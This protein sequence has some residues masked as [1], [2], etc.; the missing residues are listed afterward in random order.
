MN[1]Q[2]RECVLRRLSFVLAWTGLIVFT[3]STVLGQ[4]PIGDVL[5]TGEYAATRG[6]VPAGSYAFDQL[7]SVNNVNGSLSLRLPIA[8]LPNNRGG[9]TGFGLDLVYNSAHYD[10]SADFS[11]LDGSGHPELTTQLKPSPMNGW[12]YNY[13][14]SLEF[15]TRPTQSQDCNTLQGQYYYK[16]TLVLP[17]GSRHLL[18]MT[19]QIDTP[20][21]GDGYYP[22]DPNGNPA[23]L[24]LAQFPSL[25]NNGLNQT[26]YT[27]DGT[28][29]TVVVTKTPSYP[30]YL[31]VWNLYFPDG[32]SHYQSGFDPGSPCADND[33]ESEGTQILGTY[34]NGNFTTQMT[35]SVRRMIQVQHTPGMIDL[36]SITG[37]NGV[38]VQWTVAW[39][40]AHGVSRSYQ[41]TQSGYSACS[42]QL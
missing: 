38:S 28:F 11:N 17:D 25:A 1:N 35:D 7:E 37:V 31:L 33:R 21:V 22:Y 23:C 15:D 4:G 12:R 42:L 34:V 39:K 19:G 30:L 6:I 27:T 13:S 2:V 10:T 18:R 24:G 9:R 8:K 41:C 26:Y 14:Y 5:P 29:L 16:L 40:Y 3:A 36:V 32:S 20:N